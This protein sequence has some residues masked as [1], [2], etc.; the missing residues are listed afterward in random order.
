MKGELTHVVIYMAIGYETKQGSLGYIRDNDT[1]MFLNQ[2]AH[3]IHDTKGH[4]RS[5]GIYPSYISVKNFVAVDSL[6]QKG[7][8]YSFD[9]LD[10]YVI[11]F[12]DPNGD[13]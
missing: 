3:W 8:G 2:F 13:A 6:K 10:D 9:D 12:H 7:D 5:R 11:Q 4:L 1:K